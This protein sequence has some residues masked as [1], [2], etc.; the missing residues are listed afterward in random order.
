M[1]LEDQLR[2]WTDGSLEK[3]HAVMK[4]AVQDMVRDMQEPV[5]KGGRMPVDTGMLRNSGLYSTDLIRWNP[6]TESITWGWT[7]NY[8]PFMDA[9]YGFMRLPIQEWPQY[10][11]NAA[12]KV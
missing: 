1:T 8:A 11:E 7:A 10:V 5:A 12:R 3:A 2:R 6:E 9:R 4:T